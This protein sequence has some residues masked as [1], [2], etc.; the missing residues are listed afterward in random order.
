MKTLYFSGH[1]D[2]TFG[3]S[4]TGIDY[5]N[6]ANGKPITFKVSAGS[7]CVFVTGT[8]R[9]NGCWEIGVCQADEDDVPLFPM[10]LYFGGYSAVLKMDVPDWVE[11]EHVPENKKWDT[12]VWK[13]DA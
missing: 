8:Y 10:S 6:C 1:S 12:P 9:D 11:I 5:D 2:D 4:T 13:G 3:E 7:D